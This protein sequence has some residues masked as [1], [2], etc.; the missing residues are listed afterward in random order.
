MGKVFF[1]LGEE[2]FLKSKAIEILK[3]S[4]GEKSVYYSFSPREDNFRMEEIIRLA[5]TANLFSPHQIIVIKDVEKIS[6]TDRETLISY[7]K[8]PAKFTDLIL[9]TR[10]KLKK[11][12]SSEDT[13]W[14]NN[15][16]KEKK[17][18]IEEF[19][20]LSEE[21]LRKWIIAQV[22]KQ[23]K[24]ISYPVL[25][26]LISQLGNDTAVLSQEIE[27]ISLYMGKK[28]MIEWTDLEAIAGREISLD[29]Y[30]LINA[31][32]NANFEQGIKI[33]RDIEECNVKP[34]RIL[35][36]LVAEWRRFYQAKKLLRLGFSQFQI[37]KELG[38]FY[39]ESFFSNLQKI[40]WDKLKRSL[41][42]LLLIDQEIKTG[43]RKPFFLLESWI[44]DFFS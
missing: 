34:D 3:N 36:A 39:T 14:L 2:E 42:S 24:S 30:K 35:G 20:P 32:L 44:L 18:I 41:R 4:R 23:G 15:L 19:F 17:L 27:K 40:S 8:N 37:K 38:I 16:L 28:K 6:P 33:L 26:L 10:L 9:L 13:A 22:N 25:N 43:G 5:R 31:L 21:R 29:V 1:Y 11:L 7:I 12:N